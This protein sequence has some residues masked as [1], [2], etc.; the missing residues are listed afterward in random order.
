MRFEG[1]VVRHGKFWAVEIP[2]LNLSTQGMTLKEG[3]AMARAVVEDIVGKQ[4]FKVNLEI[5]SKGHFAVGS[6]NVAELVALMLK[7]QRAKHGLS[8]MEVAERMG[9]RSPNAFGAYEQGKREPTLTTLE[10]LI[11]VIDPSI[12]VTLS[13]RP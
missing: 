1:T 8:L 11:R 4:G 12:S 10:K 13:L 3:Y 6:D 2:A 9:S 7:R 5:L